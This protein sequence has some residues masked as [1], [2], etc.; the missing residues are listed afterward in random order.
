MTGPE[1]SPPRLA[2]ALLEL[3]LPAHDAG[4][5]TGD[6]DEEY[7]RFIRPERG[8]GAAA[9]WYW[10]QVLRSAP[11]ILA[12][13]LR[14]RGD[15]GLGRVLVTDT[16]Y[17]ARV[18]RRRPGYAAAAIAT[19][20][21]ALGVN[22]TVFS[23]VDVVLV[24]PLPF[25]HTERLVR[26]MP[27]DL[28][29]LGGS[30]VEPL[31]EQMTTFDA[32]SAWGRI[33]YVFTSGSDAEEVRG[34][35]VSWHHFETLGTAPALGRGFV[36]DDAASGDVIVLSH[37]LWT[38]R[39]GADPDI[40]G[41]ALDVSGRATVVVGV[42]GPHHVPMEY[43]WEAWS[44]LPLDPN[45][46][47]GMALSGI[48]RLQPGATLAQATTELRRVLPEIRGDAGTS[49][50]EEVS[51][52]ITIEQLDT[53]LTGDH[54]VS[55]IVL[56]A[57]VGLLLLLACV[58]VSGLLVAQGL[59]R[60]RELAVRRALG[61]SR[62]RLARQR[63]VEVALLFLAGCAGA[64]VVSALSLQWFRSFLPAE[65]PRVQHVAVSPRVVAFT[66]LLAASAALLTAV[67]PALRDGRGEL[68]GLAGSSRGGGGGKAR[69][70]VL[71]TLV[72]VEMTFAVVLVVGAGLMLRTLSSLR[73]VEPGFRSESVV[74]VRTSPSAGRYPDGPE[75]EAYYQEVYETVAA[76]PGI[77]SVGGIQFLPM[78]PGGWWISWGSADGSRPGEESM[79]AAR[80]VRGSY[81]EAM[82]I[83]LRSGRFPTDDDARAE[84]GFSVVINERLAREAFPGGDAV[85]RALTMSDQ[86]LRVI[87]VV[88]DVRQSDLRSEA[89]PEVYF[90][91]GQIPWRRM[92]MVASVDGDPADVLD[93]VAAAVRGVDAQ[94]ALGGPRALGEV[95]AGTVADTTLVTLLLTLFGGIGMALGAVGV[96]GVTS[97]SV[98]ERR[99]EIGVR[100]A[101]GAAPDGVVAR[102]IGRGMVP[103]GLGVVV[104]LTA[105]VAGTRLLEGLLHGVDPLDPGTFL[106]APLTLGLVAV[107][108][109][110]VPAL[111]AS[112][113]D[114][115]T[116][117]REE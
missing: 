108:A 13:R 48:A 109:L 8:A 67:L 21:L 31:Q 110:S 100:L 18:L 113:V 61:G 99:R 60:E 39:F 94:V 74:T 53:W 98:A 70:R 10:G 3:L 2:R 41:S 40:V 80:V 25:E 95:V 33:P 82:G 37:D 65:L 32:F 115:V 46:A 96:Y 30:E 92:H 104:G 47:Q 34:A 35:R 16:R 88:A 106:A 112:R 68:A 45:Q 4:T 12:A 26:P 102:T 23:V 63:I 55:M 78:T 97:Q 62:L 14:P 75:L 90:H 111:R 44:P 11:G 9:R 81:F 20:T 57:A 50:P 83:A 107:A 114:P 87:G 22:T 59:T 38:R 66:L 58:N 103:V 101:L 85:G 77:E 105:A 84:T 86:E 69:L 56:M 19:L 29:F 71:T 5:L 43:D 72:A 51:A 64:L 116:A 36:R 1:A 89:H 17:A 28:F 117:L 27:H 24:T 54:R 52:G 6:L 91:F 42:M 7:Q 49:T 93:E 73:S 76:V 79:A 15:Q